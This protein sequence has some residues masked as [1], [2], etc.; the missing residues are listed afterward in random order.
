VPYALSPKIS[1][2]SSAVA[3]TCAGSAGAVVS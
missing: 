2:G 3:A 1:M